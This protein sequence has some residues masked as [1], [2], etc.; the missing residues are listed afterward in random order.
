MANW[1][2]VFSML[3]IVKSDVHGSDPL[4]SSTNMRW[5]T[6]GQLI[7]QMASCSGGGL[8]PSGVA[9]KMAYHLPLMLC[10]SGALCISTLN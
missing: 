7:G 4:D 2:Y 9:V 5:F 3:F 8:S 10:I 6:A 1:S